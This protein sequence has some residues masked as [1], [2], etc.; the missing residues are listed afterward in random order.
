M[1]AKPLADGL[2]HQHTRFDASFLQLVGAEIFGVYG[3][4]RGAGVLVALVQKR[5]PLAPS[6]LEFSAGDLGNPTAEM[7]DEKPVC[8]Y[9]S[10]QI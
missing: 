8:G 9:L 1:A 4:F 6:V 2:W 5:G 10:D 7:T 3:L